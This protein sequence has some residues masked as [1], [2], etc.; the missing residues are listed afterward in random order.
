MRFPSI[1]ARDLERTD[2]TLP[3]DLPGAWRIVLMPFKRWQQIVVGAWTAAIEPLTAAHPELTVWEV[4][5]L[6]NAWAPA[7]SYIDGGMRAGIPDIDVRRH[8]LTAYTPLN[9]VAKELDIPS[10]DEVQV[11]LLDA[12]GEI[13]WRGAG[14][15]D[16]AKASAL[17]DAL[18]SG[19]TAV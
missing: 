11:F 9:Q 16:T 13:V 10:F 7:R 1:S 18:A 5:T 12:T 19:H 6:S 14:D 8:T 17:A 4:P 3:D 2:Y 15:P